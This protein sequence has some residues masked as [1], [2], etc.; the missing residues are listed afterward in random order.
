MLGISKRCKCK[1][2]TVCDGSTCVKG[3]GSGGTCFDINPTD[4][5]VWA[6]KGK[7]TE[8]PTWMLENCKKSCGFCTISPKI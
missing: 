4:C 5:P 1:T 6:N 8:N 2:G 3:F 7:C